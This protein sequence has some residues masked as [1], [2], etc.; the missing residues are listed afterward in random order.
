MRTLSWATGTSAAFLQH[1]PTDRGVG[2]NIDLTTGSARDVVLFNGDFKPLLPALG[3]VVAL[4][5]RSG[6]APGWDAVVN[7]PDDTLRMSGLAPEWVQVMRSHS[8][9]QLRIQPGALGGAFV[10]SVSPAQ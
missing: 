6:K 2:A 7:T 3:T 8:R 10:T 4:E 5:H 9:I 1:S